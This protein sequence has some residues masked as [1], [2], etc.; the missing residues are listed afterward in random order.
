[1]QLDL[2]IRSG[3]PASQEHAQVVGRL[4]GISLLVLVFVTTAYQRIRC[5]L[6]PSLLISEMQISSLLICPVLI[7]PLFGQSFVQ[8]VPYIQAKR[9]AEIADPRMGGNFN[10]TSVHAFCALG[11]AC[12]RN[13]PA[14]RPTMAEIRVHLERI[15][16]HALP[17]S[18]ESDVASDVTPYD[19]VSLESL[20]SPMGPSSPLPEWLFASHGS[21]ESVGPP[22]GFIEGGSTVTRSSVG[23]QSTG[24]SYVPSS[25]E[26]SA[27]WEGPITTIQPR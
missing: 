15:E 10:P 7:E 22:M 17:S 18:D 3:C 9:S 4:S 26:H 12:I 13:T 6:A 27:A 11:L 16:K 25:V 23:G 8:A 20:P 24:S 19:M 1:M 14:K 2:W 5:C 21:T